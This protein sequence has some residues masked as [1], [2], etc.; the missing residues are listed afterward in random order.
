MG[1]NFSNCLMKL[2]NGRSLSSE[3]QSF[4]ILGRIGNSLIVFGAE[5]CIKGKFK[6][7]VHDCFLNFMKVWG[8]FLYFTFQ[9]SIP[10]NYSSLSITYIY[11]ILFYNFYPSYTCDSIPFPAN[12]IESYYNNFALMLFVVKA[13][14]IR[15][16]FRDP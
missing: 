8:I 5:G 11:S 12:K 15:L 7:L 10:S 16:D 14:P 6:H 1:K 13:C 9:S 4:D 3:W 2:T